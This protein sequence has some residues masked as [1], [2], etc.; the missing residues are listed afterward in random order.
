MK[1]ERNVIDTSL[2][3]EAVFL[4]DTFKVP[5]ASRAEFEAAMVRNRA[6]IRTLDGFRGDT[7]LVRK[8]GESFD[9]AT[10]AAWESPDT[11]ARAKDLVTAYYARIGFDMHASIAKWG[12]TLE[13]TICTAPTALQ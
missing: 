5:S 6:F 8:Q 9:I 7:V 2:A 10:I 11:I 3:P 12:V 13:R 1:N 4:V